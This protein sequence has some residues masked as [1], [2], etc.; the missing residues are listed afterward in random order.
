MFLI[1]RDSSTQQ[2]AVPASVDLPCTVRP[3]SSSFATPARSGVADDVDLDRRIRESL[4][5]A[6]L[7]TAS[8]VGSDRE[9]HRRHQIAA[10]RIQ[11]SAAPLVVVRHSLRGILFGSVT[12]VGLLVVKN[13]L[14]NRHAGIR[15]GS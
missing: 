5:Q 11:D 10:A 8:T 2:P 9:A 15:G 1:P 7:P 13:H 14:L 4:T 3:P 12:G 6:P